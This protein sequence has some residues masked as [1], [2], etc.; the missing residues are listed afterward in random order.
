MNII[1]GLIALAVAALGA[2]FLILALQHH[3]AL[4]RNT[5]FGTLERVQRDSAITA[6]LIFL[7]IATVLA[8]LG[9]VF[10]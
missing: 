5:T 4:L 6:G 2:L 3:L 8:I 7:V 10:P 1:L 9:L